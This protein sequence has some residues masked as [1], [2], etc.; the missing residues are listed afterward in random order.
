MSDENKSMHDFDFILLGEYF[1]SLDRQGPGSPEVTKK[2]LSFIDNLNEDSKIADI[3]CG[4]GSQTLIL[5]EKTTGKITGID[6][7]PT[8]VDMFNKR[9]EQLN[10]NDR[11]NCKE[12]SMED[13]PFEKE[14]LDLIWSEG[15]IYNIGYQSGLEEWQKLLKP[16]GFI[17]VSEASWFT[18]EQPDEIKDFWNMEYPEIDTIPN[19]VRQMQEAGFVPVAT[20]IIPNECWTKHYYEPQVEAQ[21]QFLEKYPGNE[22]AKDLVRSMVV[23]AELFD[24]YHQYYGYAF[25][26]G[27]KI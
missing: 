14:E 7:M 23:E 10:L 5:A 17:A 19:K 24:K 8:F 1:A 12:G 26:I 15:A 16:G 2:A 13:L 21:K 25:F 22:T 6:L 3:G 4:T 20:F 18:D 27:K 11:L 9:I